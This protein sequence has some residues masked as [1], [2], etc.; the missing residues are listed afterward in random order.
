MP[1]P[2]VSHLRQRVNRLNGP[3]NF[4]P[5]PEILP[6]QKYVEPEPTP[7]GGPEWPDTLGTQKG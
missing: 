6:D 5:A 7:R 3:A 1:K 4:V 2:S